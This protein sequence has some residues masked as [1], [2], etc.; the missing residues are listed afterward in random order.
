M[1][2][3]LFNGTPVPLYADLPKLGS[4]APDFIVTTPDLSEIRLK[5]YLGQK[6]ILNIFPSIDTDTCANVLKQFNKI[7]LQ[8]PEL[9][10]IC[11][12]AD[13]P[14]AQQRVCKDHPKNIFPSSV[15]RHPEFGKNYGCLIMDG[16]LQGLLARA[17]VVIDEKGKVRYTELIKEITQEPNYTAVLAALK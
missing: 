16:A 7:A 14:F 15:F 1:P 6:I 12:S 13:L 11:I 9:L 17:I 5:N 3:V 8:Y 4:S 2:T 10:I